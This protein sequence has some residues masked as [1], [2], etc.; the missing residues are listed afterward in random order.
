LVFS[1]NM[2]ASPPVA[3]LRGIG[4]FLTAIFIFSC[5]DTLAKY[6]TRD[7]HVIQ[8]A[9]G[10]YVFSSAFLLVLVPRYGL[11][12]PL[13]SARPW[14]QIMRAGLLA[15]VSLMFFTAVSYMPL[16]NVT[17]IGFA[18]PLILTALGH[19]VLGERVGLRRWM[20]ILVGFVGV[21]VIIRPGVDVV[22]WAALIAL[23]MAAS[24][25]VYQ[26]ATRMLAGVDSPQTTIFFTNI[27]GSIGFSFLIPFFWTPPGAFGWIAMALLGFMGGLGHYLLIQAFGHAPVSMLAP[28]AYTAILWVT[29]S[30][31]LVFEQLPDL[32]TITGA[33]IIIASGIYVFYREAYLR[34]IGKL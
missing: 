16:V 5:L 20:A 33:A 23:A 19:F 12:R 18:A 2:I 13:R 11:I 21:M 22:H 14:F 15:A 17:A 6:L 3:A 31:Y 34:R 26:L 30:G 28:F 27:A 9:W 29:I 7:L 25:A 1:S 8:I 24:N 32:W 4:L 10:R